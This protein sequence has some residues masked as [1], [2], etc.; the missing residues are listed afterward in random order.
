MK[1]EMEPKKKTKEE[2]TNQITEERT[3]PSL[4]ITPSAKFIF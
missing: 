2:D 3:L 1:W 4:A